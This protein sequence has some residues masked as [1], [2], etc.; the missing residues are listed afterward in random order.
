MTHSSSLTAALSRVDLP[1]AR[2]TFVEQDEAIWFPDLFAP[3]ELRA[4]ID[5][6]PAARAH[7]HRSYVPT[8][9][10]GGSV[11]ITAL[12]AHTPALVSWYQEPSFVAFLEALTGERLLPC[13]PSDPHGCALYVYEEA[14]DHIAGH[15]DTSFYRGKRF[16]VLLGLVDDSSTRLGCEFYTRDKRRLRRVERIAT[17]PGTLVVFNGDR[18]WHSVSPL[19]ANE[20]RISLAMEYVTDQRMSR[21]NR[22]ISDVKDAVAYFGLR[23]LL[24][25]RRSMPPAPR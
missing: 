15:Y 3:E 23:G 13:P 14:G 11:S 7:V 24:R 12:Q 6:L 20:L 17:T 19:G 5:A 10:K 18:L 22:V 1:S 9:R 2:A 16:T 21:L 4:M 8:K 25:T